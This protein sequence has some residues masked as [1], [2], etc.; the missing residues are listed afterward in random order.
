MPL[1]TD[2][3]ALL[4]KRP[5]SVLFPRH[6]NYSITL[7]VDGEQLTLH[8]NLKQDRKEEDD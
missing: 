2:K 8:L 4:D 1:A 7:E 3:A 6:R 5:S